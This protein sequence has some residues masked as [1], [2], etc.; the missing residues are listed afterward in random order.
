MNYERRERMIN[1]IF[2][3]LSVDEARGFKSCLP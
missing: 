3:H 1:E 2:N